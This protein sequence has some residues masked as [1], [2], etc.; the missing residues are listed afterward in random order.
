M[1]RVD[2]M[3]EPIRVFLV[4]LGAFVP[5]LLLAA[6]V[7]VAGWLIA[8]AVRFAVIKALRAVNFH[9]VT[10]RAG[11]DGFL[12]QGGLRDGTVGLFGTLAWW[13]VMLAALVIAFNGLGLT[14]ITD[15]LGKV[16]LFVP[17][18]VVAL[19]IV[20]FGAYFARFVSTAVTAWCTGIGLR[21]GPFLGRL[22]RIAILVFV[23]LIALDQVE[24]GGDIVRQSFLV[25][26][27]GVVLALAL[28]FGLGARDRAEEMLERWWPRR[29]NG[30]GRP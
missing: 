25:V 28:A 8:K 29:G 4:Q 14:Y 17:K 26:L 16:M 19:V 22:A 10:D 7:L 11:V 30:G 24:V 20:A 23:A 6:A 9:V 5:R 27:A 12:A 13:L 3:L 18:L 1:E 15:L 21:D 2:M